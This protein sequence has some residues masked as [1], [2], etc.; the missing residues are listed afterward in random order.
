MVLCESVGGSDACSDQISTAI[1]WAMLNGDCLGQ[2]DGLRAGS[3]SR[4]K[5]FDCSDALCFQ[6]FPEALVLIMT[7]SERDGEA[8]Q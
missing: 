8:W 3:F 2:L 1:D 4:M 7:V 5:H 6:N